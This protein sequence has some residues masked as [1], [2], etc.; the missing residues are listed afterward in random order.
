MRVA[1]VTSSRHG[2]AALCLPTLAKRKELEIVGIIWV[3]G[4][5]RKNWKFYWRKFKKIVKIGLRGAL[6]GR[7]IRSWYVEDHGDL[8]RMCAEEGL[9]FIRVEKMNSDEMLLALSGLAADVGIS[10]GNGYIAERVFS[11][12]KYGMINVHSE[13]LP[14]YQNAQSIIWP[15]H[16]K[17]PFTGFTIHEIS[18]RIDAGRILYQRKYPLRFSPTLQ[19]TV[20]NNRRR[21][22]R[23]I[24]DAVADVAVH[25]LELKGEAKEQGKGSSYTTPT[26]RQFRRMEANNMMFFKQQS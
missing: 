13:I 12:P 20:V 2:M 5:S 23:D 26:I 8:E 17:D 14:A 7:K 18:A 15:I 11:I 21:V 16:N 24:P 3:A 4:G 1:I 6:N 19:E 9:K 10:L 25:L 22:E